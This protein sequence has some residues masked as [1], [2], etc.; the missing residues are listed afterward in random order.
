MRPRRADPSSERTLE[1][2]DGTEDQQLV[3]RVAAGDERAFSRLVDRWGG[4]L[5]DYLARVVGD[6]DSADDLL[7]DVLVA[8]FRSA[9][10]RD[11]AQPLRVWLF[12]IARN[13]ALSHLRKRSARV[14][15]FERLASGPR[16]LLSRFVRRDEAEPATTLIHS[17]FEQAFAAAL[18]RL[19]EEFSTPFLLREREELS[20]E[21]I[22]V[23]VG[24]PAKKVSTRLVRAREKLRRE[25]EAWGEASGRSTP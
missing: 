12:C 25:L 1:P 2:E 20:Y 11:R 17:E 10:Q 24:V 3:D 4:R 6:P 9:A 8:T 18:R 19:P 22:A 21:E 7:Q 15:L 5:R 16:S 13:A 23:I 14:R